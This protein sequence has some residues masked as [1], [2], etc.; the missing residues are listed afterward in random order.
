[1]ASNNLKVAALEAQRPP[2]SSSDASVSNLH[3]TTVARRAKGKIQSRQHYRE[4]CGLLSKA[5]EQRL[6]QHI[7]E[8]TRRGL[9]PNHHNV[10]IFAQNICGKLPGK[11]WA[12]QF[13]RR[14]AESITSEYLI[15]FDISRK[16]AD[17]W[18]LINH[19]FE[20]VQEKWKQYNYGPENVYNMDEKGFMIGVLQKTRR[21][22]TKA[23]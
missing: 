14:H 3:R 22:F 23:W 7:D 10:R 16:K 11:N 9:P 21:I 18:W 19:Y 5:Q 17:N 20:L 8:L 2:L 13:V 6:L 15:G 12:S 1:M 4:Q